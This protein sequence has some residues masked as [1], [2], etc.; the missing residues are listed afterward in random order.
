MTNRH[1][2]ASD[3]LRTDR[4][5]CR[6]CVAEGPELTIAKLPAAG[7]LAN[8]QPRDLS[9]DDKDCSRG[10]ELRRVLH[11]NTRLYVEGTK[12][13][14]GSLSGVLCLFIR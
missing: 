3:D 1:E 13:Q 8:R 11:G 4:E 2:M 10:V 7:S 5:K 14:V 12:Y 9:K 6:T